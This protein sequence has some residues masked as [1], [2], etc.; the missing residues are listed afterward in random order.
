MVSLDAS[1]SGLNAAATQV[2]VAANNVANLN[3]NGF[4]ARSVDFAS[5]PDGGVVA[6]NLRVNPAD[7]APNGSNVDPAAEMVS[8]MTGSMFFKANATVVRAQNELLGV[9]LDLKA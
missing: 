4:R 1:L 9:V 8:L 5:T 6:S 7:P 3:T 2:G